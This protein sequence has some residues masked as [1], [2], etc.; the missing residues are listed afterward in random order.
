MCDLCLVPTCTIHYVRACETCYL[1]KFRDPDT[2]DDVEEEDDDDEDS[3]YEAQP[4]TSAP[5]P[6]KRRRES[7]INL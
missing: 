4:T 5:T 3:I 7:I 6:A 1:R 2:L